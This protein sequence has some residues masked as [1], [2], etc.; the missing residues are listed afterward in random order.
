M[1]TD[2]V[3]LTDTDSGRVWMRFNAVP[4]TR[5]VPLLD[6][7]ATEEQWLQARRRRGERWRI[8]ASELAAVLDISPHSSPFSLWWSKQDSWVHPERTTA[9]DLG[10]RLEDLIGE[11]WAERNPH[12]MLCRPGF[13]LFGHP[14]PLNDW[15][16]CTP[17]FLAVVPYEEWV[18]N[19]G[20]HIRVRVEPVECKSDDG[21][22]GWGKPG[23]DEVPEHHRVQVYV[24]C[25]ILGAPRGHLMRLAGKRPAAYVLPYDDKARATM[26]RW[27][28]AGRAFIRSLELDDPPDVDGHGATTE[29]LQQLH[30][31]YVEGKKAELPAELIREF[32]GIDELFNTVKTT[33]EEIRN[34]VRKQLRDAQFGTDAAGKNVVKRNIY[35]RRGYEVGAAMVDELRRMS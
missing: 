4:A 16:V 32:K 34:R 23:T 28:K 10:H 30:S 25:E 8:G 1:S 26:A 14:D 21:G 18:D 9:Q 29:A 13:A 31:T 5:A 20:P 11:L 2:V 33:R 3:P 12:T 17:D 19:D 35:K 22:K 7:G 15:L 27:L 6:L 24:Q